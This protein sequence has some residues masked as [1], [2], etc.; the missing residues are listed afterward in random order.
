MQ[1]PR[2]RRIGHSKKIAIL[3]SSEVLPER[4]C[5]GRTEINNPLLP[6]ALYVNLSGTEVDVADLKRKNFT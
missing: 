6:L 1:V 2:L 5:S 4:P 3:A